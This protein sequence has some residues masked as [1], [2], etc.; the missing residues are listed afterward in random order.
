MINC[1]DKNKLL[2]RLSDNYKKYGYSPCSLEWNKG[3]QGIRFDILTSDLHISK[4]ASVIDI[5]CGFGDLL[6]Y[7]RNI[8]GGTYYGVD[9]TP[10]FINEAKKLYIQHVADAEFMTADFLDENYHRTADFALVSGS[11]NYRFNHTDNYAF[12]EN[13]MKKAFALSRQG[14]SF[15]FLSDKVEWKYDYAWYSNPVVILEMAYDLSRNVVLRNDYMPFE[16]TIT[17]FKDDSFEVTD[18]LFNRYKSLYPGEKI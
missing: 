6:P 13:C 17:V 9:V 14:I 1:E 12:I 18:T 10:E 7:W 4:G 8:G 15:N 16:F 11:L 3:K 5:G 2:A